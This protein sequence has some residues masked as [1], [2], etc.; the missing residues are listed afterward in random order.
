MPTDKKNDSD[1]SIDM[2]DIWLDDENIMR[3]FVID[4]E[5]KKTALNKGYDPFDDLHYM[6]RP[7]EKKMTTEKKDDK[8][9]PE[10]VKPVVKVKAKANA[11]AKKKYNV[12]KKKLNEDMGTFD[13]YDYYDGY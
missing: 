3:N 6:Y 8:V 9:P 1:K 13:K 7:T 4:E 2:S 12:S 5:A 10:K 11:K